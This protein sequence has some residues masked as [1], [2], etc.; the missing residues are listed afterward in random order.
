MCEEMHSPV[1]RSIQ[2]NLA[3]AHSVIR[4]EIREAIFTTVEINRFMGET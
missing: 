2:P 4:T 1:S 3:K